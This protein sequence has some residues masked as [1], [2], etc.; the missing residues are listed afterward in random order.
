MLLAGDIGGTKTALALYEEQ[1]SATSP[2]TEQTYPSGRYQSLEQLVEKFLDT[3]EVRRSTVRRGVFGVAGPVVGGRATLPNLPWVIDEA[4]L[5]KTFAW[6]TATVI[7]DLEAIGYAVPLLSRSDLAEIKPGTAAAHGNLA[8]LAPGTGL[9]ETFLSREGRRYAVHPSEGGHGDFAPVDQLQLGLLEYL[10]PRFDHVSYERVCSGTGIPNIYA[11]VKDTG[12]AE[13]PAGLAEELQRAA[14]P[15]AVI[16]NTALRKD[17]AC[18]ICTLTL[19]IFVSILGAEAGNMVLRHMATGGLYLAGGIPPRIVSF[20]KDS[21]FLRW[22]GRK[23][24][25]SHVLEKVPVYVITH[26]KTALVGAAGFGLQ[27]AG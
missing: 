15:N 22:F 26:P 12:L 7:N 14:D 6:N 19:E 24:R 4:V 10:L 8:V 17:S 11:Y 18:R 27:Q 25:L 23:G 1:S 16:I 9:G 5:Q 20:L 21:C 2:V 13:E 3:H